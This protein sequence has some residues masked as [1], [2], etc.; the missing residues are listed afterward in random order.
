MPRGDSEQVRYCARLSYLWLKFS[1]VIYST[2]FWLIGGLVLSVGIYAEVER[3]KYKT[4]ESAFLAPAIILIL[5]GVVMFIVSFIGVL[6]SLRDNLCLLQ[7][8]MYI[9]G[10]CLI[11][12]LVGGVVALIF[13]NQTIDFLNDNIRRGIENY[14]DDLDFKNIMDFVQKEFKCC[15]GEDYRDWSKNQYHDCSAPGPLACGVPYTCCFRNTKLSTPC[16]ATEL[17]TRRERYRLLRPSDLEP[18]SHHIAYEKLRPREAEGL[19]WTW[20]E[21]QSWDQGSQASAQPGSSPAA[22]QRAECHL[23]AG[24]HQRRAHLVHGQL[25]HHG[26]PPARHPAP[27]VPGGAADIPVHHPGGGHHHGALCHRR[28][29]GTQ[30]QTQRGGSRRGVLHVLPQLGPWPGAAAPEGP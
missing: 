6:A 9:L 18:P 8:F 11:I 23:R 1:L 10:I 13:R 28:A 20:G 30:H 15:G 25:H 22:P 7:A 3:Q 2:V 24:L 27:P 21:W 19:A 16:A 14:Y 12:E 29:P 26:G 5:L 17:L 4:L